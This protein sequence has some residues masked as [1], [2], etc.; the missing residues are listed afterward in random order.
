M[1]NKKQ[2]LNI[3]HT[4]SSVLIRPNGIVRYINDAI[5]LQTTAQGLNPGHNVKFITDSKTTQ[6]ISNVPL[7]FDLHNPEGQYIP[8]KHPVNDHV[9]LQVDFNLVNKLKKVLAPHVADCDL[10]IAHDLH[11]YLAAKQLTDQGVFIQHE[12]DVLNQTVRFSYISD[13]YLA[14]QLSEVNDPNNTWH[15]GLPVMNTTDIKP[16]NSLYTPTPFTFTNQFNKGEKKGLLY[17]GDATERKGAREFMNMARRL[18]VKPT[19]ISWDK[20]D[21]IFAGADVYR[22]ELSQYKQMMEFISPHTVAFFPNKNECP[23]IALLECLQYMPVVVNGDN[24]WT[25]CLYDF[26]ADIIKGEDNIYNTL[27]NYL[28]NKSSYSPIKLQQRSRESM[29]LWT[30][31][32]TKWNC[33]A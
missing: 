33:I 3:I 21:A 16:K 19:V 22:F 25:R 20:D 8:N 29:E 10:I 7:F 14:L 18:N 2:I 26:G 30:Q 31:G 24:Q 6:T 9:W 23:S 12:S 5:N 27:N 11:S 15:I 13:E 32:F 4:C 28:N 17:I 1:K